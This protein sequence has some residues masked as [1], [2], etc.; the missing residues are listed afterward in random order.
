MYSPTLIKLA[1]TTATTRK[2][3]AV[4]G[5]NSLVARVAGLLAVAVLKTVSAISEKD[6]ERVGIYKTTHNRRYCIIDTIPLTDGQVRV[7]CA[8]AAPD[9]GGQP[10]YCCARREHTTKKYYVPTGEI[11]QFL[12]HF[13]SFFLSI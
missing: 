10:Y 13:F 7:V 3:A 1:E 5:E 6:N 4:F 8:T 2:Y 12:L 11:F 9:E